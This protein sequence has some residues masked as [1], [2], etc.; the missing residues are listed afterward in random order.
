MFFQLRHF[1]PSASPATI[2]AQAGLILSSKTAAHVSTGLFWG[3]FADS[4]YGSRKLVLVVGLASS[5]VAMLGYGFSE[6]IQAAVAWQVLDGILNSSISMIRCLTAE[7]YPEKRYRVR[8]LSLLPLCASAGM[9]AGPLLG[10]FLSSPGAGNDGESRGIRYPFA[11]PNIAVAAYSFILAALVSLGLEHSREN[12]QNSGRSIFRRFWNVR[13]MQ[14]SHHG[15]QGD[16]ANATCTESAPLLHDRMAPQH[17]SALIPPS[18]SND[19]SPE[20]IQTRRRPPRFRQIWTPNVLSTMLANFII[21]GHLGTFSSLWAIFLSTPPGPNENRSPWSFSGG[22]GMDARG[23]GV[24]VTLLGALSVLSQIIVYPSLHDRFGTVSVWRAA[25]YF[26]PATYFLAPFSALLTSDSTT[27]AD[28]A[29]LYIVVLCVLLLFNAGRTGVAPATSLLINDCTPHPSV[30]ATIHTMGT[31]VGNLGRSVFPAIIL[32]VYGL[33]LAVGVAG[34]GFWALAAL[35][36][37][38]CLVS[39][40]VVEGANGKD[41]SLQES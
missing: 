27:A 26:F 35:A 21:S 1:D 11:A 34:L 12:I 17:Q 7:L 38:A 29:P 13:Q 6:S 41:V 32:P 14:P 30:R 39:G 9:F 5:G 16:D 36:V 25:L 2:S 10:G 3:R 33:G 28:R 18:I 24:I 4:E 20:T 15:N 8:A 19:I 40:R 22:L 23:V 31:I 37:V